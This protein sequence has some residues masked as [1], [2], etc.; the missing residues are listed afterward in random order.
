MAWGQAYERT[1]LFYG[2][3]IARHERTHFKQIERIAGSVAAFRGRD[4][5]LVARRVGQRPP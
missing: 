4:V 2:Q 1:V 5:G 3:R